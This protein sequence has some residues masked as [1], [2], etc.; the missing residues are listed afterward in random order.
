MKPRIQKE[1]TGS[2]A[3]LTLSMMV[4]KSDFKGK[5]LRALAALVTGFVLQAG[6][7]AAQPNLVANPGFETGNTSGWTIQG[8]CTLTVESSVVHTPTYAC[9]VS[10]RGQ[11]YAGIAQSFLG[12]LTA[13]ETYNVSVWVRLVSG[14]SQ[15]IQVTMDLNDSTYTDI[16]SGSVSSSGWTQLSGQYTY[17]PSGTVSKLLLYVEVP[18]S[19]S[20]SYYIDDVSVTSASV[21]P[22]SGQC[23]VDWTNVAQRIDG[24]GASSAWRSDWTST[25]ADMFFGTNNGTGTSFNGTNFAF[26]GIGLSLL[27]NHIV[28]ANT[29]SANDTPTTVET[30]IMQMAQARGARVWSAPWTPANGFKDNN[31]SVGGNFL[32]ASNQAYASQLAN[33][34]LNMKTNWGVTLYAISVQNEPDANV[35]YESCYWYGTNFESFVTNLYNALVAK[36]VGSTKIIMPESQNWSSNPGLWT[37]TLNDTNAF[38]DVSI[39]ANHDYVPDNQTGDLTTPAQ[40]S[41]SGASTWETEVSQIGGSYDGSIANG[42]YWAWRIHLYLTVAQVNAWHYWWLISGGSDN[43]GL[44]DSSGNPAKRMYV[45]GQWSRFVRPDFYRIDATSSQPSALI[46]AYKDTNSPA[47]AIVVVNTNTATDV[48]QTFNLTNFTATS[49]TPWI[50][51]ASLSLAPQT[52]VNVANY[53]FTYDIPAMSVVTFVGQGIVGL[54]NMPPSLAPVA[55][56]TINVGQT[57]LVTNAATDPNVPPNT[58]NFNLLSNPSGAT[59]TGLDATDALFTWRAPVS[60]ADTTNLVTVAVTDIGTSLSATNSFNVIVNAVTNPVISAV[61]LSPGQVS[62]TVNGPQG[63]DYTL[64]TSTNLVGWQ[65]LFTTNSPPIPFT[66]SDPNAAAPVQFYRFQIGP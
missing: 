22:T 18:N 34:V 49:V 23:S 2:L 4:K 53:S 13:G 8:S 28:A 64:W 32:S 50:T 57:L 30:N 62:M 42:I 40:L 3:A 48:M 12:D 31:N 20:T 16:A 14:S 56:Q 10:G 43:E 1:N 17:N 24:F 51:S 59:L 54:S 44:T 35:S 60:Q 27:R 46:S 65:M 15:N 19:S 25:E 41:V 21:T 11:T 5:W 61:N 33:Y 6:L 55:D 63:P 38:A 7:A 29:T 47:F 66:A 52:P 39:I 26:N 58:L 36:G 45:L 9:E 37:P